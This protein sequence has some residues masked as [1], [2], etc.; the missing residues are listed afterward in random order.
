MFKALWNNFYTSVVRNVSNGVKVTIICVL[1]LLTLLCV[2]GAFKGGKEGKP[3]K[4]WFL[5]WVGVLS[6]ALLVTYLILL[7]V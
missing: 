2:I 5:F 6:L 3:I 7:S 4:N 1:M